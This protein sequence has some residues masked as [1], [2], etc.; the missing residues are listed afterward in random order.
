MVNFVIV[1]KQQTFFINILIITIMKK[2]E[3]KNETMNVVENNT[4]ANTMT[5]EE[6]Q[7]YIKENEQ[8]IPACQKKKYNALTDEGK[9]AKIKFYYDLKKMRED[10]KI[11]NSIPNKVKDLFEIKHGTVEDAKSVMRFCQEFID[12]F[13]QREVERIDA[14]IRKLQLM[15]ESIA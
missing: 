9:V 11:K 14:E 12:G 1:I 15:K 8:I 4:V 6:M 2:N 10:A 7:Q 3:V 5:A 13:K